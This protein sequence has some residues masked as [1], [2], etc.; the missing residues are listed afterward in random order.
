METP[1][2]FRDLAMDAY[3]MDRQS[4]EDEWRNSEREREIMDWVRKGKTNQ[5]IGTILDISAFTVKNH[6]QRIFKKLGVFNRTQ[7]VTRYES[8]QTNVRN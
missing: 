6:L 1:R 7:A 3:Q 2:Q 5:E 4:K 8:T